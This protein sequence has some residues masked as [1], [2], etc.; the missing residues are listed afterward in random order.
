[1]NGERRFLL[2]WYAALLAGTLPVLVVGFVGSALADRLV[3]AVWA[4]AVASLYALVLRWGM[5]AGWPRV[6]LAGR[7]LLVL[8]A[9]AAAHARLVARH[10]EELD[11][12]FRAF[13]PALYHPAATAPRS[14]V[15][16]AW[17]LTMGGAAL[18][19]A[20]RVRG[21]VRR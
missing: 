7:S 3:F 14:S 6:A 8:A 15:A 4:L 1:M 13:L 5:G 10:Q 12:A 2:T 18:L 19:L 11:L 20:A 16:A 21:A 9:G 17:G